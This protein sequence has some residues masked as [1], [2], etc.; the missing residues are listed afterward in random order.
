MPP[1]EATSL[2]NGKIVLS[3]YE[4]PGQPHDGVLFLRPYESF[5]VL[6]EEDGVVV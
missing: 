5:V 3:N 4:A 6:G 2:A 1:D